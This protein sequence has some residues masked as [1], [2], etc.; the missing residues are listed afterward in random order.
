M[1]ESSQTQHS[2]SPG[3]TMPGAASPI[4]STIFLLRR[5]IDR[6]TKD[7]ERPPVDEKVPDSTPASPVVLPRRLAVRGPD[8]IQSPIGSKVVHVTRE[9][10]FVSQTPDTVDQRAIPQTAQ[11]QTKQYLLMH[12]RSPGLD[13]ST[14]SQPA[15]TLAFSPTS[16]TTFDTSN[17]NA[18]SDPNMCTMKLVRVPLRVPDHLLTQD[19]PGHANVC[20]RSVMCLSGPH[21]IHH[22]HLKDANDN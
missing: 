6:T 21:D 1:V 13:S 14:R 3:E 5:T 17:S 10:S 19:S 11:E 8:N 16:E 20:D 22:P 2:G 4:E 7:R 15:T 18:G 12:A 9:S